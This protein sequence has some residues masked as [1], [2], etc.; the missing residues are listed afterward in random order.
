M[1][2]Y[3]YKGLENNSREFT[4][5]AVRTNDVVMVFTSALHPNKDM[6]RFL[7][8][9]GDGVRKISLSV[10]DSKGI[11]NRAIEKGA[12]GVQAP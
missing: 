6:D 11:Y 1:E 4:S 12:T 9:H 8:L 5:R 3:A 7:S 2:P 10:S